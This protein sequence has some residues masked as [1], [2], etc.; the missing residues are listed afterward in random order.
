MTTSAAD[1]ARTVTLADAIAA[2]LARQ[3]GVEVARQQVLQRQGNLQSAGGRFDWTVGSFFSKEV[4]R[5]P[6]GA[7]PPFL[8][9]TR[10]DTAVYS[11][12]V[13]KQ[14]RSGVGVSPRISVVDAK[15]TGSPAP[16]SF[17][18]VGVTFT[19]PLLR[20]FGRNITGAEEMAARAGV[21]AQEAFARFQIERMVFDTTSS[22]WNSLAAR[23][24]L[25]I[26]NDVAVRARRIYGIVEAFAR[27]GEL[28]S[29]ALDQARALV[30]S[31]EAERED[32]ELLYFESRQALGLAMGMQAAELA[33]APTATGEFPSVVDVAQLRTA[34]GEKYVAE[35]LARRGDYQAAG[36]NVEAQQVLL[37]EV[38]GR[39][40]PRLDLE[41][42]VGYTGRNARD[43][44]FRPGRAVTS[45]RTG[46]NVLGALTLE[47]P[48]ANNVARGAYVSQRANTEQAR[49]SSIQAAN[50]I[51][52]SVLIG[53]ETLRK[54]IAQYELSTQAVTTYQRAVAQTGEKLK[55]NEASLTELID[56]EDR[57]AA[58]RRAQI[59]TIRKYAVT[60]AE[61]RL[62]TGTLTAVADQQATFDV[63]SL[64]ELPPFAP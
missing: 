21:A 8:A 46:A 63:R 19:V 34:V 52:A 40:K 28:D 64:A 51:A 31:K 62:N 33:S 4:S 23:R 55:I 49:L 38:R 45:D 30:A 22:Y 39:M 11:V 9:A 26:L 56:V 42:Q 36:L 47:W 58:A 54:T 3:P 20:G 37:E 14:F 50:G 59:N 7:P 10:D 13:G 6:T 32:G 44:W 12:G 48:V 43:S 57:Y 24:N 41:L 53:L 35:A 61:L 29:A 16:V 15:N 27:G 18:D 17:A 2:T 5:V 60:I 25:E 1:T